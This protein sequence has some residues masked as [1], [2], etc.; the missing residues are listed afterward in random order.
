[1]SAIK[2]T[3]TAETE[4]LVP[5]KRLGDLRLGT[6]LGSGASSEVY[7]AESAI[8]GKP[9]VAKV[10]RRELG[11]GLVSRGRYEHLVHQVEQLNHPSIVNTYAFGS[12]PA[13]RPYAVLS[14][15][16]GQSIG[17]L[18]GQTGPLP[19]SVAI[20]ILRQLCNALAATH[21]RGIAHLRLHRGNVMVDMGDG[22]RAP[23]VM[24]LDFGVCQLHPPLPEA[25]SALQLRAEHAIWVAPEQAR[26][27][28]GDARSDVYALAVLL[29]ELLCGRVP[30]LGK[31][32]KET[33]EL[34]VSSTATPPSKVANVPPEIEATLLRGLEKDPK[35]RIPSVEALLS[36]LDPLSAATGQHQ[37]RAKAH[38]VRQRTLSTGEFQLS[39]DRDTGQAASPSDDQA[40]PP[41]SGLLT[42]R[43]K[44]RLIFGLAVAFALLTTA[45]LWALL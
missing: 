42:H 36:E 38:Q 6:L 30:F 37:V 9:C 26:G 7:S 33:L 5:G 14:H 22:G 13:G 35:R 25:S 24:L 17:Q 27:E 8:A 40:S 34:Q 21:A 43:V 39:R 31:S 19:R 18:L 29:Y 16:P 20:A 12:T 44:V 45:L 41:P 2:Q 23:R 1:V 15:A 28:S 4:T 11:I 10:F 32:Y 3:D